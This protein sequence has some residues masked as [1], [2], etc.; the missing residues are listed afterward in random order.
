VIEI[1]ELTKSYGDHTVVTDFSLT[2]ADGESVA[3]WGPNG[4]G[5]TTVIRSIL[6]LVS[7]DGE[8]RVAGFDARNQG[9]TV[10]SLI[11]YV[12]QEL[13]FYDDMR[14]IDLLDYSASLRRL[15]AERVDE[16]LELLDLNEHRN[17]RVRELS[18]G[19]KQRLGLASALLP[20][21]PLLLLDEP[22]SNLDAHTR[23]TAL[24]LLES[25][26][27]SGRTLLV[28]SHHMEE[29][30]MLVDRV[31]AMDDGRITV[32][33]APADLADRLG[34]RAWLHIVLKNR[35]AAEGVGIL[36]AAGFDAKQNS[37]GVLV[38][39]SAQGKGAAIN[40]LHGAGAEIED[41]EVWR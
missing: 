21:P 34:I 41:L 28:T 11:G 32:E 8:I 14:V 37:K 17:K 24:H 36:Q 15:D 26:R 19:L 23:D 2:V 3:L 39:V 20:D 13:S 30:G 1:R 40:A 10:R 31:I 5:K 9:K 6:G 12:P 18:G 29:A 7:Y 22:T 33:C 16:V 4:A 35:T 27:S 25:L 38:E